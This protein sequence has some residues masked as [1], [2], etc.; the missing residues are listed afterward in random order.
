MFTVTKCVVSPSLYMSI[1]WLSCREV[2]VR[3]LRET[4]LASQ[5][6]QFES[7]FGFIFT[8]YHSMLFRRL[9]DNFQSCL[10]WQKAD[11]FRGKSGNLQPCRWVFFTQICIICRC[12]CGTK[13]GSFGQEVRHSFILNGIQGICS[14][15]CGDRKLIFWRSHIFGEQKN[16]IFNKK[17]EHL[18]PL[19]F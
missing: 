17:L 15:I 3:E 1:T 13:N 9:Q 16:S 5:W 14:C 19:C 18:H 12:V 6:R 11:I 2:M 7:S 10:W 4:R 8:W